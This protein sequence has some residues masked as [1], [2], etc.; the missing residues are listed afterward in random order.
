MAAGRDDEASEE[1]TFDDGWVLP[2]VEGMPE[3]PVDEDGEIDWDAYYSDPRF[4]TAAATAQRHK[5]KPA[6]PMPVAKRWTANGSLMGA[7]ALGLRQVFE[8]PRDR[9]EVVQERDDSG[10]PDRPDKPFHLDFDPEDPQNTRAVVR[11]WVDGEEVEVEV[12][13]EVDS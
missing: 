4:W 13:V 6:P 5:A 11:T 1:G 12:D 2:D 3:L 10:D 7:M 9:G 8:G